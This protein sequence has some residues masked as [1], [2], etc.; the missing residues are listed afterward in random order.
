MVCESRHDSL[1][2][3]HGSCHFTL[4][5]RFLCFPPRRGW[6]GSTISQVLFDVGGPSPLRVRGGRF[7]FPSCSPHHKSSS[8][9]RLGWVPERLYCP[10]AYTACCDGGSFLLSHEKSLLSLLSDRLSSAADCGC[11]AESQ[12]KQNFGLRLAGPAACGVET[13]PGLTW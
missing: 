9:P 7:H 4:S 5:I 10:A 8:I 11:P 1:R 6:K 3:Y 13:E 2:T 12:S